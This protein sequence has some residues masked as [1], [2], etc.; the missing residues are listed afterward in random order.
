MLP[1][2][3]EEPGLVVLENV[4][5]LFESGNRFGE[6]RAEGVGHYRQFGQIDLDFR[7]P[8]KELPHRQGGLGKVNPRAPALLFP[9]T[10][11]RLV[12]SWSYED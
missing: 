3:V 12:T 9:A 6:S 8:G 7:G 1:E 10:R 11:P 5:P 4:A 2:W